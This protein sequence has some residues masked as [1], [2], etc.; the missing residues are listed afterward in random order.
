VGAQVAFRDPTASNFTLAPKVFLEISLPANVFA[1]AFNITE[2]LNSI[3]ITFCLENEA[4]FSAT[5]CSSPTA[6]DQQVTVSSSTDTEF[7]GAVS[8]TALTTLW[9]GPLNGSGNVDVDNFE[10][11]TQSETPEATTGLTLGSGLIAISL[12]H[13]RK[14]L[15]RS[16]DR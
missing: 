16:R 10:F 8:T 11:G 7:I 4:S 15:L 6:L 1:V 3:P 13:R 9:I 14:R 12:L 5:N 2:I